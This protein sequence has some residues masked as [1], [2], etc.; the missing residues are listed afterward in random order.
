M[1]I[2]WEVLLS[3]DVQDFLEKQDN[4]IEERLRKGLLK[5][6]AEDPFVFLE[7]Y[8]GNNY[9]KYRIGEYRVLIDVDFKNK[10]LKIQVVDHRSVI[11]KRFSS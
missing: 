5:L 3:P 1:I 9:Y 11:Y 8:E 4:H 10:I 7:H 2:L 6:K